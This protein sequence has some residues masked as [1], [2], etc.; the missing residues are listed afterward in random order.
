MFLGQKIGCPSDD[1][2]CYQH[3]S[4]FRLRYIVA[5]LAGFLTMLVLHFS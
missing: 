1:I 3:V 4:F 5:V 2:L